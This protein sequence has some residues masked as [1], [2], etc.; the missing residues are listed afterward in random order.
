MVAER[1]GCSCKGP[2]RPKD[3]RRSRG[4]ATRERRI[5][6]LFARAAC[7]GRLAGNRSARSKGGPRPPLRA[8]PAP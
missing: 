5:L 6:L 2:P 4:N 8:G 1:R 7:S 3:G